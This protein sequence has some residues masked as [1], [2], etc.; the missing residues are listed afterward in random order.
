[1]PVQNP[2]KFGRNTRY[3]SVKL[4]VLLVLSVGYFAERIACP[5]VSP[6]G[7]MVLTR[8][9]PVTREVSSNQTERFE[10]SSGSRQYVHISIEKGDLRLALVIYDPKNNKVIDVA[11]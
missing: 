6:S 11:S 7:P 2:P 10:L 8:G 9:T 4:G 1:M 5:S 3:V